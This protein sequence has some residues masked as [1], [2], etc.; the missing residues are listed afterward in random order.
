MFVNSYTLMS[1]PKVC[2]QSRKK[3]W[4]SDVK[5]LQWQRT[6][7]FNNSVFPFIFFQVPRCSLV[8]HV[9]TSFS[10]SVRTKMKK[11]NFLPLF[12]FPAKKKQARRKDIFDYFISIF[13]S[14]SFS[15]NEF[16]EE[17]P[18]MICLS[19]QQIHQKQFIDVWQL[20]QLLLIN[21]PSP[22]KTRFAFK[23]LLE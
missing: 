20:L 22:V 13:L 15:R 19:S 2:C 10:L 5:L 9:A 16:E 12:I 4:N 1:Y 17:K 14:L 7:M 11:T 18:I 23:H 21:E 3:G 8:R 6:S